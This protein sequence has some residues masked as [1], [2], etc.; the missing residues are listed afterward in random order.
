MR[1]KKSEIRL[2][3]Q[4]YSYSMGDFSPIG[5][6][7]E[8]I[9]KGYITKHELKSLAKWKSRRRANFCDNNDEIFVKEITKFSFTTKSERARIEALTLLDGVQYST[10]STILHFY[11]QDFY[12]ILDVRAIWSL[13]LKVPKTYTFKFWQNYMLK[14]RRLSANLNVDMRTLDKALWQYSNEHQPKL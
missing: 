5:I 12:P 1:L 13:E 7:N 9:K 8:V 11:H 10:A 2:Y 14:C 3:A 6:Q 4:R